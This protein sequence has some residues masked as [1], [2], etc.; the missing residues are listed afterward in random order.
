MSRFQELLKAS[1]KSKDTEEWID[2]HFTR[3]V[4]LVFVLI[5]KRFGVHPNAVTIL[6]IFLGIGAAYCFYFVD[7]W[8]N[9]I[10]VGLLIFANLCDSTDGQLARLT[11]Q[12]S[13]LGRLLDGFSGA[14]WFSCIYIALALRLQ[15][16]FMPSTDVRWGFVIWILAAVSGMLCHGPQSSLSDY[17]RQ[18]HLFFLKGTEGSELDYSF[19]QRAI[20]ESLDKKEWL[21]RMF[22]FNYARYCR[23][24]ERRTPIFQSFFSLYQQYPN[25]KVKEHFLAG[26]K[27]LML[28]ANVLTFNVRAI[29]LY[30]SC[31]LNA[32][33]FYFI[34]EMTVLQLLYVYMHKRHETLCRS[35]LGIVQQEKTLEEEESSK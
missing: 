21:K 32:P 33:W 18:I 31:L 14:M 19:Q 15:Q 8:H 22:Y 30:V 2:V 34:F 20:Y 7:L 25:E 1:M 6:S 3:P 28:Y 5:W 29:C 24:Q 12:R 16:Q 26:S 4:G 10:G 27:P 23:S 17:Y 35:F 9:I 11:N 13:F